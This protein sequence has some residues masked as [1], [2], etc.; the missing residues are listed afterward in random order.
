MLQAVAEAGK[1][2]GQTSPNPAVGAIIV[3]QGKEIGRGYHRACGLPHAEREAIADAKRNAPDKLKGATI[4]VTLEPCSTHGRTPPC[5]DGI[6]DAGLAR[7][8]YAIDDPNPHHAGRAKSV[9]AKHGVQV[10]HGICQNEA[11]FLIRGFIK[12]QQTQQPWV[13]SKL[14]MSLD[15]RLSRPP[16]EE[17][18]LTCQ[19]SRQVVQSIRQQVDAILIGPGTLHKDNPRL[20]L[21]NHHGMP[22]KDR[23]QPFRI[24]LSRNFPGSLVRSTPSTPVLYSADEITRSSTNLRKF[25]LF[26]DKLT[27]RTRYLVAEDPARA[28][29]FLHQQLGIQ[30]L[31]LE[32]GGQL[33]GAFLDQQLIDE[34]H[35]FYAP[36]L[37]GGPDLAIAGHGHDKIPTLPNLLDP[38]W[39]KSDRDLHLHAFVKNHPHR[40]K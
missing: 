21:R 39:K 36:M 6:A 34:I 40:T 15:G 12:A 9:L 24:V 17:Q 3:H 26:N 31:L 28:I 23:R 13:I 38:T 7:C 25:H 33:Q 29:S 20:N 8:V 30:T 2:L 1:G 32:A 10:T 35:F 16:H 14:A 37:C 22:L 18:W 19:N 5:C 4:Y 27:A 11:K